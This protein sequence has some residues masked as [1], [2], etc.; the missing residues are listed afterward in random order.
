MEVAIRSRHS[1]SRPTALSF[2][3]ALQAAASADTDT[4]LV[5]VP[6]GWILIPFGL[7]GLLLSES[8]PPTTLDA[9]EALVLAGGGQRGFSIKSRASA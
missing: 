6:E 2:V 5:D 4:I 8:D 3:P 1:D 7:D 9:R